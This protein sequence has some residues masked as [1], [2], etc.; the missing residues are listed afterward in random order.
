MRGT[1]FLLSDSLFDR[2]R[3]GLPAGRNRAAKAHPQDRVAPR[4]ERLEICQGLGLLQG[5]EGVRLAGNLG[6]SAVLLDDL[7]EDSGR[8]S[9]LV[10]LSGRVKI[11]GAI[12]G[13]GGQPGGVAHPG[14][15]LAESRVRSAGAS[16]ECQSRQITVL[17]RLAK[18]L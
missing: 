16:G 14:P 8:R 15:D 18:Q 12:A 4:L 17:L 2:F 10:Q 6:V 5:R 11:S 3:Q 13:G 1:P 7:E 9:R